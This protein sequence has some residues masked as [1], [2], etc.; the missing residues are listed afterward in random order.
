M[1]LGGD[2]AGQRKGDKEP[3]RA[4]GAWG[5]GGC[6]AAPGELLLQTAPCLGSVP[7]CASAG[8]RLD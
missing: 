6:G 2:G 5:A 7:P 8:C 1:V 3:S 4:A